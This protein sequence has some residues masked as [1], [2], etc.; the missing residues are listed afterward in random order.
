MKITDTEIVRH[1]INNG[2]IKRSFWEDAFV[3]AAPDGLL[4][5]TIGDREPYT[6]EISLTALA[7]SDWEKAKKGK[8]A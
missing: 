4:Q 7:A 6:Y 1:L 2:H 5:I 3:S 8:S